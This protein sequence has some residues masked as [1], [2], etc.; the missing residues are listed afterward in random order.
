MVIN[1]VMGAEIKNI[2]IIGSGNVAHNLGRMVYEAGVGINSIY[3]RDI[4]NAAKL[5]EQLDAQSVD[6][7]G[8]VSSASEMLLFAVKDDVLAEVGSSLS[9]SSQI[10]AHTSGSMEMNVFGGAPR[11]AVFYPLQ[12][13][14]KNKQ[15]EGV[16]FPICI[17]A[18]DAEDMARLKALGSALVGAENVYEI[19]SSQRKTLHV[20]AVFACNFTNYFFTIAENI[21]KERNLSFDLLKPLISE[22]IE[23]IDERGPSLNQTGPAVRGD[24]K[25]IS[26]HLDYLD[27]NKDYRHLYNLVTEQII[28]NS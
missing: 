21:L 1:L 11:S 4:S 20:A 10:L 7:L 16:S 19:D 8:A 6:N 23:K 24:H 28:K 25:I 22:T 13:F 3:S 18:A 5:A 15:Y 14:S 2:S 26:N 12:T 17:E 9:G 27:T